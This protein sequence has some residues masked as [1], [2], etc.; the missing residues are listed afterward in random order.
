MAVIVVGFR[1][2]PPVPFR[3]FRG[4]PC[5]RASAWLDYSPI[6]GHTTG[7]VALLSCFGGTQPMY[8]QETVH[9]YPRLQ[10]GV[11]EVLGGLLVAVAAFNLGA[12]V[13]RGVLDIVGYDRAATYAVPVLGQIVDW[14][15]GAASRPR[16]NGTYPLMWSLL[17]GLMWMALALLVALVLRNAFPRVRSSSQGLLVEFAN[18]WLPVRWEELTAVK[19]TEDLAAERFVLLAQAQGR[20]LTPWHRLYSFIYRLGWRRGF[21]VTSNISEFDTLVKTILNE[22]GRMARSGEGKALK[23]EEDAQSPLFKLMLSPASFLS[24]R[25]ADEP[26]AGVRT[27]QPTVA[28]PTGG[29][30]RATYP[31]RISGLLTGLGWLFG[32]L[33]GL[34]YLDFWVRFLALELPFVRSI[35]PFS[36]VFSNPAYVEL[37]NGFRTQPV[38]FLGIAGRP[39]L[40]APWWLLVAAHLMLGLMFVVIMLVRNLL[41]SLEARNEGLAVKDMFANRWRILPWQAISAVKATDISEESQFVMVQSKRGATH[42]AGGL[43]SMLYDGSRGSGVLLTSA[44]GNFQEL[45]RFAIE[46]LSPLEQQSTTPI[47]RQEAHSWLLW[48]ALSPAAAS[49]A[50][51]AEG[52]DDQSTLQPDPSRL[53]S[54][55]GPMLALASIPALMLFFTALL[56]AG[57]P[58]GLGII[59]AM[60][61]LFLLGIFEWPLVGVISVILDENTGGGEENYRALYLYPRSQL[62]RLLPMGLGIVFH[63][64]GLPLF[65]LFCWLG[66]LVWAFFLARSLFEAL[67]DWK[68]TQAL[69]GGLLPV[70]YQLIVLVI[71]LLAL[72]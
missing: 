45:L 17:P 54:Y 36:W 1:V 61:F 31:A 72:R 64:L 55:A 33:T 4:F 57:S 29:P 9:R 69:L 38:P 37:F 13:L 15:D 48:H 14:V 62:P 10:S 65:G 11:L 66:T 16:L 19:V 27:V 63:I 51:V 12:A 49:Q 21:W 46:K 53:V 2:I 23:L 41:P 40:P 70:A 20:G 47:L 42:P 6:I 26:A 58:P 60:L 7:S 68:D 50:L 67:Y 44:I 59:G 24:R 56:H 5:F 18:D 8:V 3:G 39:D 34:A 71:F 32:V 30:I 28:A 35:P 43:T 52:R 25:A 22:T